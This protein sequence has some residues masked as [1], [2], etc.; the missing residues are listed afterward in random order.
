MGSKAFLVIAP[1]SEFPYQEACI[2]K[3][4]TLG[5]QVEPLLSHPIRMPDMTTLV[6]GAGGFVER[7]VC[8]D[9]G[10]ANFVAVT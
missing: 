10:N 4:P 6:F 2:V 3:P 7:A 5:S 8:S 9:P 1:P